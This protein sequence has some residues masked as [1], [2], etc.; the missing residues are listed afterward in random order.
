MAK[1]ISFF[2]WCKKDPDDQRKINYKC[3]RAAGYTEF[4]SDDLM[5]PFILF[6]L[7][8]NAMVDKAE[9][10]DDEWFVELSERK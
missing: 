7:R 10:I 1:R 9:L 2:N 8:Y 6:W 5:E 3:H 4:T